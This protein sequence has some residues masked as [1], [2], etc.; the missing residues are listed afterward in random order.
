MPIDQQ[1]P[2]SPPAPYYCLCANLHVYGF[3]RKYLPVCF[4]LKEITDLDIATCRD[5]NAPL[6]TSDVMSG[7][8]TVTV[9]CTI[10]AHTHFKITLSVSE[11]LTAAVVYFTV[12]FLFM[13]IS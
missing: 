4:L 8:A 12:V 7:L 5:V 1:L 13:K 11:C 10:L 2:R 6:I 9:C 3:H